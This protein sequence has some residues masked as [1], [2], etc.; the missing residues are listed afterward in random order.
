MNKTGLFFAIEGIDGCG[1]TTLITYLKNRLA[2]EK[3]PTVITKEPGGSGLGKNLRGI[4]QQQTTLLHA[5][6]EFL[7]FAAD[8]AQHMHEVIAPALACGSLV[9][10][11]R[12][13]DSSLAYQ[14]YGLGLDKNMIVKI[15][16]W[17]MEERLPNLVVYLRISSHDALARIKASRA[18]LTTF[19][20]RP[21]DFWE[22]VNSG[23]DEIFKHDARVITVDASQD[24]E[25]VHEQVWSAMQTKIKQG[26]VCE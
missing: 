4:L 6:A 2:Q 3:I 25:T 21:L 23:Y 10:T 14:G 13:A 16:R 11:D 1:K 26:M 9:I 12:C 24:A 15:N 19:E 22:R 7:L 20:Q 5:K 17:A 18:G 8:R